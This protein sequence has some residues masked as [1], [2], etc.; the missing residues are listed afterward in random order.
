M[1]V[2]RNS[3]ILRAIPLL[4]IICLFSF[5]VQAQYGG[6][7]GESNEPYLIYTADQLDSIGVNP[8]DWPKHFKLMADIDLKDFGGSSFNLIGSDLQPFNGV[9]DG[10]GHTIRNF[11]YVVTGNEEHSDET[12][13][14]NIGFFRNVKNPYTIIKDL[15]FIDPNIHPASTCS[16]RVE[17]VGVLVGSL[18]SGLI[19]D[20]YVKR[21]NVRAERMVGG[22]VGTN[23]GVI[24]EC[25]T[26]C[27]VQSAEPRFLVNQRRSEFIGGIVGINSGDITRCNATGEVSGEAR[28]GGIAGSNYG[29]ITNCYATGDIFGETYIGGLAG[30]CDRPGTITYSWASGDISGE[31][32][33]GGL[34]GSNE[35][36]VAHCYARGNVSVSNQNGGG[37]IG[38]H[39]GVMSEC[40]ATGA[41]V[42][43][44]TGGGLAGFNSGTI[45]RC[46]SRSEVSGGSRLGGLVGENRKGVWDAPGFPLVYNGII[47]DSYAQGSVSGGFSTGG[48][49][50]YI[51]G[52][53]L[54]R[55]YAVG[56]ITGPSGTGG[57]IG[58]VS[59]REPFEIEESFWDMMAS[60][61]EHSAGG[62]GLDTEAMQD[63]N[64]FV[65][66]GWDFTGETTNGVADFWTMDLK[67]D[68]YPLL[69]W[70]VEPEPLLIFEF[71]EDPNW[72]TQGQWQFG[73]PQGLG[74][75]DHGYPDPNSGYTGD[76]VYGVNLSGDYNTT[77]SNPYYLTAGPFDC[78]QYSWVKLQ[79]AR[80]LN[81][82]EPAY[83][84]N[85]VEVSTNETVWHTIW[86]YDDLYHT[87]EEDRWKIVEYDI[88]S[89]ANHQP[90]VYIRWGYHVSNN[91]AWPFSGWN[92]DDVILRGFQ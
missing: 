83:A 67:T 20:C 72:A 46:Y 37:L 82:D 6:G 86:Q 18:E 9:F 79:F 76:N 87:L 65:A 38:F 32:Q 66:A 61:L 88:G 57:L 22:L 30:R 63:A 2:A 85:F 45:Q 34:L 29:D 77:D 16:K 28:I 19:T 71:N 78:S 68:S 35:A 75:T 52:G 24:S 55:C 33:V 47:E 53:I 44:S 92:I 80:W 14:E 39:S 25:Y 89:I 23:S 51:D 91:D 36:S 56:K 40:Y 17:A 21:G 12:V 49:V 58:Y 41:V 90:A 73:E 60:N 84:R 70:D 69:T 10:N 7:T 8:G 43:G 13:T 62:I 59:N 48:L 42:S 31:R 1:A 26:T 15:G 74:G 64:T 5:P 50:G 27:Q 4:I 11:T 81:S 3:G 54:S